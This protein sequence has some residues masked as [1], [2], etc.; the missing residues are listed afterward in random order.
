MKGAPVAA[1]F[2][3]VL[4]GIH[5][6]PRYAVIAMASQSLIARAEH[7]FGKWMA[8]FSGVAVLGREPSSS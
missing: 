5:L 3:G 8:Y 6:A 2:Y 4:G 7:Y 1:F